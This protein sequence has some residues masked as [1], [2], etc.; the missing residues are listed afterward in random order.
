[1]RHP[2]TK[3]LV[4]SLLLQ[5]AVAAA[6]TP[7]ASQETPALPA[8]AQVPT[9][10]TPPPAQTPVVPPPPPQVPVVYATSTAAVG[11]PSAV[12]E[13]KRFEISGYVSP[14]YE[15]IYRPLAIASAQRYEYGAGGSAGISFSG[16]PV[17]ELEFTLFLV[18]DLAR[19]KIVNKVEY[20]DPSATPGSVSGVSVEW[21]YAARVLLER[22][23]VAYKPFRFL[24]LQGGQMR[25]P[26][27]IPQR[28]ANTA[29]MFPNRAGPN[30][31][32]LSGSDPGV[33]L[34]T[35]LAAGRILAS[36]GAFNGSSLGLIGSAL[37]E[38][39]RGPVFCGRVD[40]NPLGR[41]GFAEGDLD[42]GPLRLGVGFGALYRP[43]T[44][45]D[46]KGFDALE[47]RDFR[48]VA[49]VRAAFRGF[50]L[51]AEYLRRQR[52][53][54][55]SSRARTATGA[56][57][58]SS[59]FLPLTEH[60]ALA[61][62]ARAGYVAEDEQ[63]DFRST[64]WY[65]GGLSIFPFMNIADPNAIRFTLSYSGERRLVEAETAHLANAQLQLAF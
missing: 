38:S 49:S 28:S 20:D 50:Y 43:A 42:R 8:P 7:G 37:F 18:V 4:L 60:F 44:Q 23:T 15:A 34:S 29:L 11:L 17:P 19:Q 51:Q 1:M 45:F 56:Y 55:L 2:V 64:V 6:Q 52:A 54:S 31:V 39:S 53:D 9:P 32:F 13:S 5:A 62:I 46:A 26:L 35:D 14:E 25:I 33:L 22:A 21:R 59:F 63:I 12:P 57:A 24:S 10:L 16:S 48:Y 61:P 27:T 30:E 3:S 40:I 65:E 58:Q 36:L 47:L 41:F